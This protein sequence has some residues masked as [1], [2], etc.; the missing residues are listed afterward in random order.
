[1]ARIKSAVLLALVF[2]LVFGVSIGGNAAR[3]ADGT[4]TVRGL[5]AALLGAMKD[6][7]RLG[8]SGRYSRL[9]PVILQSYDV[10]LMA[11]LTVGPS[12]AGL[13][14]AHKRRV[15]DALGHYIAAVYADRFSSY[16]GER[17]LVEGAQTSPAG[18]IVKSRIVKS[19]GAPVAIDYLMRQENGAW[20][21]ADVYLDGTISELATR[22]SEFAGILQQRGA[23]GLIAALERK[24]AALTGSPAPTS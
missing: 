23:D 16:A 15:T 5:Y 18:A 14:E 17:L 1:M 4:D 22:R 20:R 21:I 7:P 12:W 19:D 10:P 9:A 8:Q 2:G 6:G 3:A 11:R 13:D 24:A